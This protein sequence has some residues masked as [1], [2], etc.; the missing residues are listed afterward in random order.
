MHN[1]CEIVNQQGQTTPDL[2]S[3]L[4]R[5]DLNTYVAAK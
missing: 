1:A 4:S 5:I 3:Y 2:F